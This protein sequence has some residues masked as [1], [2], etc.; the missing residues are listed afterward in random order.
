MEGLADVRPTERA[1]R[2]GKVP[3]AAGAGGLEEAAAEE[4]EQDG[5]GNHEG[6]EGEEQI[7]ASLQVV[8]L[9]CVGPKR[10]QVKKKKAERGK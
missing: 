9:L 4:E 8:L 2:E 3:G 1:R 7:H 5:E 6:E 10:D